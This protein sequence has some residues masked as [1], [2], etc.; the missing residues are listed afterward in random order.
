MKELKKNIILSG[1]VVDGIGK[2]EYYISQK[3][4]QKQFKSKLGFEPYP[5]TFNIKLNKKNIEKVKKLKGYEGIIIKGFDD[6]GKSF[7]DVK[8]FH[9]KVND[10][11][12]AVIFPKKSHYS[13]EI[14]EIISPKKLRESIKNKKV[15]VEVKV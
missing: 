14:V 10:L 15:R 13:D 5:G 6:K 8:C 12:S 11:K 4:Y 1:K 2:G 7:G 3:K 9:S